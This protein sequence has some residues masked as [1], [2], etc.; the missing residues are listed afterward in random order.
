MSAVNP[1]EPSPSAGKPDSTPASALKAFFSSLPGILTAVGGLIAAIATFISATDKAGFIARATATPT[2]T[3]TATATITAMPTLVP[4]PTLTFTAQ[5]TPT[6]FATATPKPAPTTGTLLMDDFRDASRWD[7]ESSQDVEC[8]VQGGEYRFLV[9]TPDQVYW[10]NPVKAYDFSDCAIDVD[11][12]RVAG[13][14]D[15]EYAILA[16]YQP[17]DSFYAF[18]ASSDG[19]F[20]VLLYQGAKWHEIVPWTPAQV[21]RGG[22]ATNHLR[23]ELRGPQLRLYVNGVLLAYVEDPTLRSGTLGLLAGTGT[24]AEVEVRFANLRVT[25][26]GV[27]TDA[28]VVATPSGAQVAKP[29]EGTKR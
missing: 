10:V 29:T 21:V 5:P 9:H 13:P 22:E 14:E 6:L 18:S 25:A 7:S 12:R 17:D 27:S 15:N 16:R 23:V 24:E 1:S 11:V 2:A 3:L 8:G 4:S 28:P 20:A 26:L 19:T